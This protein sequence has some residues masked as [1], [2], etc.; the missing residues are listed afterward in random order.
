MSDRWYYKS[1]T[2][3]RGPLTLEKLQE[4][5]AGGALT[6]SDLVRCG[7]GGVWI[8]VEEAV[9]APPRAT[10]PDT[11]LAALKILSAAGK[12]GYHP[13]DG[14]SPPSLVDGLTDLAG[15]AASPFVAVASLA[16]TL[17]E[18]LRGRLGRRA[19]ACA[20]VVLLSGM[21]WNVLS[22]DAPL[23]SHHRR[24]SRI[25]SQV[26]EQR[27]RNT[28]RLDWDLFATKTVVDLDAIADELERDEGW[29]GGWNALIGKADYGRWARREMIQVSRYD[30]P[31]L[32]RAGP[33]APA[34]V[35]ARIS[36]RLQKSEE[37]VA[38]TGFFAG[39]DGDAIKPPR[40]QRSGRSNK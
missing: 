25:W 13:P 10:G 16:G 27:S 6:K 39:D 38:R 14:P 28:S 35:G 4:M 7:I 26:Q 37:Y 1:R 22:A 29:A 9:K 5:V 11:R 20:V 12:G 30:L 24:L 8:P 23:E 17:A 15:R 3:V 40:R 31:A 18:G 33:A 32:L 36:E 2:G 21:T 19:A 34:P